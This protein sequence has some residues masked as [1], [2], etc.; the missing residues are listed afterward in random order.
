[1][2]DAMEEKLSMPSNGCPKMK[3]LMRPA[4]FTEPEAMTMG[5]NALL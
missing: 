1:M 2:M 3:S 5:K 4:Q